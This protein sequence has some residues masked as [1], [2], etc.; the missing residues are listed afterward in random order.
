MGVL[1]YG[2]GE[3]APCGARAE[4]DAARGHAGAAGSRTGRPG[5]RTGRLAPRPGSGHAL[6]A[7]G[8]R[9]GDDVIQICCVRQESRILGVSVKHIL[10]GSGNCLSP[11]A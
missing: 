7:R 8:L 9:I 2:Q 10:L 3:F 5:R 4:T 6:R 1:G 11:L